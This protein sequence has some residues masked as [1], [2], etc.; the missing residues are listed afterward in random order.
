MVYLEKNDVAVLATRVHLIDK[1]GKPLPD[2]QDDACNVSALQIKNFLFKDN[3][4]A[5]PSVM[6]KTAIFRQYKYRYNQK[7]SEDYDLWLRLLADGLI[8]EKLPETLVLYRVLPTSET[9]FKKI[10]VFY[11]LAKVKFRFLWPQI[12]KGRFTV[13]NA[14]LFLFGLADVVKAGGKEVK[15]LFKK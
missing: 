5:H 14:K 6:G 4:I 15:M 12:Q 11:R 2:W 1:D 9:R 8:I 3:C 10:N 13:F 7:Y